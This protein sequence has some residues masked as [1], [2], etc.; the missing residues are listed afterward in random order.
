MELKFYTHSFIF[1]SFSAIFSYHDQIKALIKMLMG[2][3]N[4][5]LSLY[6][7]ILQ[8]FIRVRRRL[9]KYFKLTARTIQKARLFPF[10]TLTW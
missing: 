7:Q 10:I 6:H 5:I 4:L 1:I 2:F 9:E 8:M 3:L